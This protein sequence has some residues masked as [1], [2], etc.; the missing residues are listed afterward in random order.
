MSGF[1]IA[2]LVCVF[3]PR[4]DLH[5]GELFDGARPLSIEEWQVCGPFP[6][7][8]LMD[9]AIPNEGTVSPGG[10]EAVS[11]IKW[12]AFRTEKGIVNLKGRDRL[13][14]VDHVAAFAYVEIDSDS[15]RDVWV[16]IGSD[17]GV[18]AWWNGRRVLAHD[19]LRGVK[20]GEDKV[21][22][23]MTKGKNTLLLKIYDAG[24]GWGFATDLAIAR[25]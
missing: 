15:D 2:F 13:G 12:R 25:K 9:E 16:E 14:L 5:A 21:L 7:D 8:R 20:R 19:V 24:G 11:G 23:K 3:F 10:G 6:I 18:M 1:L 17:D 22:V 4:T